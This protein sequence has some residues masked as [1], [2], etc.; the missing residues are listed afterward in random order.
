VRALPLGDKVSH[1]ALTGTLSAL[2]NLALKWRKLSRSRLSPGLATL[3]V[4]IVVVAKRYHK[5]GFP[6]ATSNFSISR[7][8][9][10][11]R[12]RRLGGN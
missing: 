3:V 11:N 4:V 1:F 12:V 9:P 7:G 2:T 6:V 5:S 10:G 8:L